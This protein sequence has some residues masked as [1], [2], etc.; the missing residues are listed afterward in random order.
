MAT[1]TLTPASE[2]AGHDSLGRCDHLH[3]TTSR[4]DHGEK[5]MALLLVCPVCGTERIIHRLRY[6]PSPAHT[7]TVRIPS[8]A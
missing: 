4:Y 7:P 3:E 2:H 5:L 1:A 8:G 6:E